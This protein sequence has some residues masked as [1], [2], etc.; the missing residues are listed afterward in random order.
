MDEN[1]MKEN[2]ELN[3][4][5]IDVLKKE[6][7]ILDEILQKQEEVHSCVLKRKWLE[8]E[9]SL[10]CLQQMSE[11]FVKLE[12]DRVVLTEKTGIQKRFEI[13]P[14]LCDVRSKLKKSKLKNKVLNEYISTTKQFLQGI[15]DEVLP[16]RRNV[17]YSRS[18]KFIK[19]EPS[20]VVV[21]Q[22]I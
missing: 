22:V 15:F 13:S 7:S 1:A 2:F 4:E 8:L 19:I 9:D 6:S 18:G 14:F 20:N 5:L 16:E 10:S 3:K 12:N 11:E 21:D 17:T